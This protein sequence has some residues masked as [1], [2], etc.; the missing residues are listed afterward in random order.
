MQ[1]SDV[2]QE[3]VF[4]IFPWK[5]RMNVTLFADFVLF[6]HMLIVIFNVGGLFAIWFGTRRKWGWVR[7]RTFRTAHLGLILFI[8]AEAILGVACPLTLL[9][10]WLR[11][12]V[13]ERGFIGRWIHSWLYWDLP[14]WVFI[15]VYSK[16]AALVAV[17]WKLV[18]PA[19][20][21]SKL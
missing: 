1:R 20:R 10:D 19:A 8:A 2:T 15:V 16:F 17:T 13:S 21:I 14:S 5:L 7:N 11:G 18:P 9:E 3:H 12:T 4:A 6:I